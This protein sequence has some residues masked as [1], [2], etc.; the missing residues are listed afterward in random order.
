M[1]TR[2]PENINPLSPNGYLF[3]LQRLPTL[4][5]FC[6]EISLPAITLPEAVQLTPFTKVSLAG[7]I[8][9]FDNLRVQ[10]LIDDKMQNYKAIY[11]WISGLGFIENYTQYTSTI[12]TAIPAELSEVAKSSSDA[13]LVILGNDNNAI[14]TIQF[15]DC[16]PQ[17]LESITFSSTNPD[18]TYLVGSVSFSYSYYTFT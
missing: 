15:V 9:Q 7:D 18:V 10:F 6:Q 4:S 16:I 5:Y 14:Q 17:S 11:D 3:T 2:I 1:T 8:A 12:G 13:T